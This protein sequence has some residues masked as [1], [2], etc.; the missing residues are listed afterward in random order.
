MK[1]LILISARLGSTRLSRKHLL[2]VEN[3]PI[4]QYLV[5]TIN[6]EF[7]NEIKKKDVYNI[8]ATS[9]KPENDDFKKYIKDCEVFR[10]SDGNIPLRHYQTAVEYNADNIISVDGDDILCSVTAMRTVYNSLKKGKQFVKTE[11]LPFGMNVFGYSVD[12]LKKTLE[13]YKNS[14]IL[15]TGW[16]R[17][18][19]KI[20]QDIIHFNLKNIEKLRFTLDYPEDLLFFKEIFKNNKIAKGFLSDEQ[21]VNFVIDNRLENLTADIDNKYWEN[22]NKNIENEKKGRE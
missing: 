10:G 22:F 7:D 12:V 20:E 6:R 18:F 16:G 17:I 5:N 3:K 11:G 19:S 4:L 15:E 21:I 8:I 9:T 1:T 14:E 13:N 2:V